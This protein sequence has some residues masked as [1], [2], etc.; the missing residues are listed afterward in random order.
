[1]ILDDSDG[2]NKI[3]GENLLPKFPD[4]CLTIEKKP[5]K[6]SARKMTRPGI[7]RGPVG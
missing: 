5:G 2:Q 1:M 6:P 7:E 3:P 4:I